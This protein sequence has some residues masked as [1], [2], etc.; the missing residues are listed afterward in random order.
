MN[1]IAKLFIATHVKL[2]RATCGRVGASFGEGKVLLLT[3]TG[4]KSGRERIVP[5][6][7]FDEDGKRYVIASNNGNADHP[8][9]FKNLRARP[10]VTVEVP[11]QRYAAHAEIVDG[12]TRARVFDEVARKFPRFDGY[13]K[14]TT[15]E[16]PVVELKPA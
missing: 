10:A 2:Y 5:V 1:P 16:I 12:A 11:G 7:Y 13:R 15:R 14:K 4:N 6:M 9:W 3:T 8:A